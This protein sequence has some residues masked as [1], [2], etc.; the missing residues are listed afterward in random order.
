MFVEVSFVGC[1]FVNEI[2]V[3]WMLVELSFVECLL[4]CCL[5]DVC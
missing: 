3:C 1:L 4:K 5:L 2:V